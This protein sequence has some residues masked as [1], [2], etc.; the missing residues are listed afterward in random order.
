MIDTPKLIN[1]TAQ[2]EKDHKMAIKGFK[3]VAQKF[4][5]KMEATGIF[6]R[7]RVWVS[8]IVKPMSLTYF[9]EN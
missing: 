4:F 8:C 7:D 5:K 3:N 1:S 2:F 6:C 9:S